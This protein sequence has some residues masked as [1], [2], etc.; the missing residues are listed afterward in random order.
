M[1]VFEVTHRTTGYNG[2]G[3][4]VDVGLVGRGGRTWS[5]EEASRLVISRRAVFLYHAERLIDLSLLP[6]QP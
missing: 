5:T 2:G 6:E 1:H 3:F 4:K